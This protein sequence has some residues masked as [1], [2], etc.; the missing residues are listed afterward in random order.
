MTWPLVLMPFG[1]GPELCRVG[2][3]WRRPRMGQGEGG[4]GAHGIPLYLRHDSAV[5]LKLL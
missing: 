1:R 2:I 3:L 4:K 5:H